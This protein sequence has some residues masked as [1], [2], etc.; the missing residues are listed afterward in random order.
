MNRHDDERPKSGTPTN[1]WVPPGK[2]GTPTNRWVPPEKSGT[3]PTQSWK[4]PG[5]AAQTEARRPG[6]APLT[7][8]FRGDSPPM[9]TQFYPGER[10]AGRYE[11]QH[12]IGLQSGEGDLYKC[13]DQQAG[14]SAPHRHVVVKLYALTYK[15]KPEIL[16]ELTGLSHPHIV[17]VLDAQEWEKRYCEVMEFCAGGSLADHMPFKEEILHGYLRQV[18]EGLRYCHD[19]GIVHRDIKP[20]NLLF[21]DSNHSEVVLTDFGISSIS[22]DLDLAAGFFSGSFR[23]H[24]V[25]YAAPE[26]TEQGTISI[27]TDYYALGLTLIHL[28]QGGA[29]P[30]PN[31]PH[32]EMIKGAHSRNEIPYP[33]NISEQ[34][35]RLLQGLTQYDPHNRWGYAQVDQ[36]IK[37]RTILD[38]QGKPWRNQ[39]WVRPTVQECDVCPGART[40]EQLADRLGTIPDIGDNLAE[41]RSWLRYSVG[42]T[43]LADRV[44]KEVERLF[45]KEPRQAL[46]LLYYLLKPD[47]PHEF[48]HGPVHELIDQALHNIGSYTIPRSEAGSRT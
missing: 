29:S 20:S 45:I 26:Y 44:N 46:L 8:A 41:I 11:V 27:K 33:P 7:D 42:D 38:D 43:V 39:P 3:T 35:H 36:W 37:N 32:P 30:F 6:S 22:R 34:F 19:Q 24:T 31:M 15:T 10:I 21:R 16:A 4:Q 18:I 40:P 28:I 2:G 12:R 47:A 5:S 25:D 17:K 1:Q 13:I 23:R 9:G 14:P 48:D